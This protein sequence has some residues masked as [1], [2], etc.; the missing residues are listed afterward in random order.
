MTSPSM[1]DC[2]P[3]LILMENYYGN[4]QNF[5]DAVYQTFSQDFVHSK[6]VFRGRTLGLKRH[7]EYDD[8]SATFWHMISEG[9]V[10]EDR[11]PDI[12]RCERIGWPKPI[13]ENNESLELKIWAEK[14]RGNKRI[15]IWFEEEDYLVV[16][17]DR[18]SY[19]LPWTAYFIEKDHERKKLYKRWERNQGNAI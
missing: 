11:Q 12:R 1:S 4:W 8:K 2:L 14:R 19:I 18:K 6:P 5:F 7:P 13:I 3:N 16:L 15:H 10:E 17:D 9:K